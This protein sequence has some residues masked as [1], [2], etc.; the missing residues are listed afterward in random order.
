MWLC[1]SLTTILLVLTHR[2]TMADLRCAAEAFPG[3]D[4][5]ELL[6]RTSG[7]WPRL[8]DALADVLA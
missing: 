8:L 2:L 7:G 3:A 5:Y 6:A 4:P 1:R